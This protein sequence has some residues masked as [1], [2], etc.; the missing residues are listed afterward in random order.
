MFRALSWMF[1]IN[2]FYQ[3]AAGHS[4]IA[5]CGGVVVLF[6]LMVAAP[7]LLALPFEDDADVS[8]ANED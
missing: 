1:C 2:L 7:F 3:T 4:I 6:L 8:D 5:L